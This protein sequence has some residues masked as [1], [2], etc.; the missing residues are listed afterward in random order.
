M[1][2][3]IAIILSILASRSIPAFAID[4]T[5]YLEGR[6]GCTVEALNGDASDLVVV[7]K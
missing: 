5:V 6:P 2:M 1:S 4:S 7:C 3:S